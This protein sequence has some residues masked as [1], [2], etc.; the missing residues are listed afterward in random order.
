MK[1]LKKE[2][3]KYKL[4][5]F[6]HLGSFV[7]QILEVLTVLFQVIVLMDRVNFIRIIIFYRKDTQGQ[8]I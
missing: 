6:Y 1:E 8:K 3:M 4:F 7:A 2:E 5:M